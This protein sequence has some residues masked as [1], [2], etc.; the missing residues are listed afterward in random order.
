MWAH[1][2]SNDLYESGLTD[3]KF[4]LVSNANKVCKVAVKHSWGGISRR[5]TFKDIEMQGT[6]IAPLKCSVQV[7][8]LGKQFMN[9]SK[10]TKHLY[11]YKN[12]VKIPPLSMIDD[13]LTIS[14][15]GTNSIT[16]NAAVQSKIDT[17]RL[18]L[19]EDKCVKMH[20]GKRKDFCPKLIVNDK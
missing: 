13:I 15:C 6:V 3:D 7:D 5:M 10:L 19:G 1:E 17:K 11:K 14:I 20:L 4:V 2:T 16:L 12:C 8:T 9:N 18:T